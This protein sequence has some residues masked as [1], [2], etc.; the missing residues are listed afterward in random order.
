MAESTKNSPSST[1]ANRCDNGETASIESKK[2]GTN[3][4]TAAL[5]GLPPLTNANAQTTKNRT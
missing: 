1:F 3:M 5:S 2:P 4:S